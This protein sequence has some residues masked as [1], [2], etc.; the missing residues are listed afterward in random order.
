MGGTAAAPSQNER[1][2]GGRCI[3]VLGMHRSGTSALTGSLQ[4]AGVELG[5]VGTE[6]AD[7]AKG[8]REPRSLNVLHDHLLEVN[9]GSWAEPVAPLSWQP[10]HRELRDL[11]IRQFAGVDLWG[12]KDPRT[13]LALGGWLPALPTAELVGIFRHPFLVAQSLRCRNGLSGQAA[14]ALWLYYNRVLLWW[15]DQPRGLHLV[16]FDRDPSVFE[17][18]LNSLLAALDL[19]TPRLTFFEP[20]LRSQ[21]APPLHDV[22]GA[23]DACLLYRR[24]QQRAGQQYAAS[25]SG[26]QG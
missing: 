6:A 3:I 14:L 2:S 22:P 15:A 26:Q 13:L 8:N 1:G 21:D 17:A 4:E 16:E 12:F 25:L 24:L 10:I 5:S 20:G 9:G 7:N 23:E 11:F 19:P 18:S